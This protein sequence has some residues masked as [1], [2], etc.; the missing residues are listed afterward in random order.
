MVAG[1]FNRR[2]AGSSPSLTP[3]A[4][5]PIKPFNHSRPWYQRS[6][7][8]FLLGIFIGVGMYSAVAV[9]YVSYHATPPPDVSGELREA[10]S[11]TAGVSRVDGVTPLPKVIK[12]P[13]RNATILGCGALGKASSE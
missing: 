2:A 11:W 10:T 8:Q 13:F 6:L 4:V 9:A 5:G 1:L 3:T 7:V 12:T